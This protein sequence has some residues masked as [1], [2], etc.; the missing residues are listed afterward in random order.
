[1]RASLRAEQE[2]QAL[3]ADEPF[4][5]SALFVGLGQTLGEDHLLT[6][7]YRNHW[8]GTPLPWGWDYNAWP[9]AR[10]FDAS[11]EATLR[12]EVGIVSLRSEWRPELLSEVALGRVSYDRRYSDTGW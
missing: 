1:M 5:Q 11:R 12:Q 8:Q 4:R 9:A 6:A 2:E 7:S 10:A 3:K